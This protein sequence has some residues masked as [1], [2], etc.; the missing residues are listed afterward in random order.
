MRGNVTLHLKNTWEVSD[1]D[2]TP[3]SAEASS[4][5]RLDDGIAV[6]LA[7]CGDLVFECWAPGG[8][9]PWQVSIKKFME[10]FEAECLV[11]RDVQKVLDTA[12]ADMKSKRFEV[13]AVGVNENLIQLQRRAII[14]LAMAVA[15]LDAIDNAGCDLIRAKVLEAQ[16]LAEQLW[17]QAFVQP[18]ELDE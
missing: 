15:D 16:A 14:S 9:S 12:K 13:V 3:V 11:E 5:Q 7:K 18:D 17:T 6:Y 4:P 10:W 2:L 1:S 8:T